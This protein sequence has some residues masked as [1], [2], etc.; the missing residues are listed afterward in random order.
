KVIHD[1]HIPGSTV[2]GATVL[3]GLETGLMSPG[4]TIQDSP[5]KIAGTPIKRS[6]TAGLGSVDD[7]SALKKSSNIYMFYEALRAG[8]DNRYPFPNNSSTNM[9]NSEGILTMRNYFNR[10]GLG[11]K[12][13][14]EFPYEGTGVEGANPAAGNV[15]DFAIGQYDTYTTLQLGQY[16]STIA[17]DGYRVRPHLVKE[18]RSPSLNND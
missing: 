4:E 17:N 13:G 14:I 5:I 12:T 3:T 10:F 8:G 9:S 6:Y 1:Q 18:I 7:K 11:V 15:L 2:K 16:V